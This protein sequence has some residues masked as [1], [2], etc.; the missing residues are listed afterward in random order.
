MIEL[1]TD[2]KVFE[3]TFRGKKRF[4]IRYDDR[5]YKVDDVLLLRETQYTGEEMKAGQPLIYTGREMPARVRYILRGPIYGLKE[6]W[7]I[8]DLSL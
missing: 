7:V 3:A 8:M 6:G 4:E 5:G 2:H 1:K